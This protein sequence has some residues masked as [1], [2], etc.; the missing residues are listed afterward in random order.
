MPLSK[1]D[2]WNQ[3]RNLSSCKLNEPAL[4]FCQRQR[5]HTT[6]STHHNWQMS[7]NLYKAITKIKSASFGVEPGL[8][9]QLSVLK[10]N[11]QCKWAR[12]WQNQQNHQNAKRRLRSA[13]A[14]THSDQSFSCVLEE[15]LGPYSAPINVFPQM[16]GGGMG[17]YPRE[18]DNFEKLG[19]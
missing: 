5:H 12:A 2:I 19:P 18:L 1:Q 11:C 8:V 16:G 17:V 9:Y 6:D 10:T 15:S 3:I 13:W 14:S 7:V 4:T